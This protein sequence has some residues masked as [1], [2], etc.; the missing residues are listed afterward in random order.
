MNALLI[1]PYIFDF[2]AYDFWIKPLGLLKLARVLK[3]NNITVRFLDC[4]DRQGQSGGSSYSEK[5][6]STGKY[7]KKELPKEG[8]L[9]R[10]PRRYSAYG[11]PFEEFHSKLNSL[12][13]PDVVFIAGGLTYRYPG[14]F[15]VIG[16]IKKRFGNVPVVLGGIYPTL[17]GG[18]AKE[19]SGAD[20]V[21]EGKAVNSIKSIIGNIYGLNPDIREEDFLYPDYGLYPKLEFASLATSSGCPFACDYCA[22][23]YLGGELNQLDPENTAEYIISLIRE[24]GV[25]DIVFY[26]DALF[27][28]AN[29]HILPILEKLVSSGAKAALHAPNAIHARY[30]DSTAADLMKKAGFKTVRLGLESWDDAF[31]LSTGGKVNR[32]DFVRAALNLKKAGFSE[33]ETGSYILCGLPGTKLTEVKKS[34]D[35]SYDHGIRPY[36]AEYSPVPHT[37]IYGEIT[38]KLGIS[39]EDPLSHHR[40]VFRSL[41]GET[42]REDID[43]LKRY[44][45]AKGS[46]CSQ[47]APGTANAAVC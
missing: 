3:R 40:E 39:L 41:L 29:S 33:K 13:V 23:A 34:V 18:H 45:G 30:I 22:S 4:L 5:N 16:E 25:K 46:P 20:I 31:N 43:A 9:K 7:F 2:T 8:I 38:E 14:V 28:R 26:D 44:A 6:Y 35:F 10:I 47:N 15:Y 27:F 17:C 12:T 42:S 36:L 37:R 1:D 19:H 32:D 21:V 11:I 24:K